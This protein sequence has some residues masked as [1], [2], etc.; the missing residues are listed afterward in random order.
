MEK[1]NIHNNQSDFQLEMWI[2]F[3]KKKYH[4]YR[5][6]ISNTFDAI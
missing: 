5:N 3:K 6:T 2:T 1:K 4:W